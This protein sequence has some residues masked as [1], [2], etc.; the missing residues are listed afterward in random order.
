MNGFKDKLGAVIEDGAEVVI[1][2]FE[3][4]RDFGGS[5]RKKHSYNR[6]ITNHDTFDSN[7]EKSNNQISLSLFDNYFRLYGISTKLGFI[8]LLE[9]IELDTELDLLKS[10][11]ENVNSEDL[12]NTIELYKNQNTIECSQTIERECETEFLTAAIIDD[13]I[14]HYSI[15]CDETDSLYGKCVSIIKSTY[16]GIIKKVDSRYSARI[17]RILNVTILEKKYYVD[18]LVKIASMRCN[19]LETD[20]KNFK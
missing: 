19:V 20:K 1:S 7:L 16:N 5:L 6:E 12:A 11:I 8:K 4:I 3:N 13:L 9:K 14:T 15:N 10:I 18:E 17:E 2:A